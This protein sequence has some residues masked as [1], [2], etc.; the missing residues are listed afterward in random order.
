MKAILDYFRKN[1]ECDADIKTKIYYWIAG[2]LIILWGIVN[3]LNML[4]GSSTR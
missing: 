1:G 4:R 3:I 2:I